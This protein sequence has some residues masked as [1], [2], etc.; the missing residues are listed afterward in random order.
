MVPLIVEAEDLYTSRFSRMFCTR[1]LLG[2]FSKFWYPKELT[3]LS[4]HTG[5]LRFKEVLRHPQWRNYWHALPKPHKGLLAP[6]PMNTSVLLNG[7]FV[8]DDGNVYEQRPGRSQQ[9][10][11]AG[12]T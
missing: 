4:V 7:T 5:F 10:F 3:D 12:W 8:N 1:S 11:E 2:P 9:L 6:F